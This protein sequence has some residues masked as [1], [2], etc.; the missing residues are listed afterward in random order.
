MKKLVYLCVAICFSTLATAQKVTQADLQ[1]TWK[2]IS[3]AGGGV[4]VDVLA[5]KFTVDPEI[6]K[7]LTAETKQQMELGMLQAM[8]MF[9]ESYAVID[10]ANLKQSMGPQEQKGTFTMKEQDGKQFLVLTVAGA[11][12]TEDLG[13]SIVDKKLHIT[14]GAPGDAATFIYVKQ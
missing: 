4:N 13:V 1:G 9:K 3:F 8:E 10:G 12:A 14:Q 6:E 2:M 5:E 11:P 7:Q